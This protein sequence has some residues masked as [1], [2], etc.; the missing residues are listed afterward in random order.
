MSHKYSKK[1]IIGSRV[2]VSIGDNPHFNDDEDVEVLGEDTT[3]MVSPEEAQ[4]KTIIGKQVTVSIGVF[5]SVLRQI[6]ENEDVDE[7]IKKIIKNKV[8]QL[9]SELKNKSNSN[10]IQKLVSW[11]K[12][13]ANWLAP[14][15]VTIVDKV[16]L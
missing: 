15:I 11:F 13:N 4:G 2:R 3:V 14:T 16:M 10:N 6:D 5:N 9:D 7:S 8:M 1:K 12:S